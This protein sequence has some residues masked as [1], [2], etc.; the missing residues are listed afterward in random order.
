[1]NDGNVPVLRPPGPRSFTVPARIDT[2]RIYS[3][4]SLVVEF[5]LTCSAFWHTQGRFGSRSSGTTGLIRPFG[6]GGSRHV[7]RPFALLPAFVATAVAVEQCGSPFLADV[8]AVS[9]MLDPE[10]LLVHP[11]L[12]RIGV[13]IPVAPFGRPVTQAPW[14]TFRDRTG[15]PVVIDGAASFESASD[16]PKRYLGEIPVMMSFHATKSFATGEGGCV[17]TTAM[18]LAQERRSRQFRVLLRVTVALPAP[19][20]R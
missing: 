11:E 14:Q 2:P 18:D 5:E 8:D 3:N 19:M 17:A 16:A 12:N 6:F 10:P 20:A 7:R 4:W 15:I 1:M 13:V 9:W